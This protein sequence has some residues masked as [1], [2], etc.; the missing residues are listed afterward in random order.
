MRLGQVTWSRLSDEEPITD[1]FALTL[2]EQSY[3]EAGHSKGGSPFDQTG[4][5]ERRLGAYLD[6]FVSS[7]MGRLV[8]KGVL[9]QEDAAAVQAEAEASVPERAFDL[10]WRRG[11]VDADT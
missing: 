2:V 9:T 6:G 3:D 7:L 5:N 11:D 10:F 4:P 1:T 8:A